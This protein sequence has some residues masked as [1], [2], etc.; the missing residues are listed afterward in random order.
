MIIKIKN[1]ALYLILQRLKQLI[2]E[3]RLVLVVKNPIVRIVSEIVHEFLEGT[4]KEE[5]KPDIDRVILNTDNSY[6][7]TSKTIQHHCY[8]NFLDMFSLGQ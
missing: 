3:V 8:N 4:L 2:P 1:G 7:I 6:N 5:E